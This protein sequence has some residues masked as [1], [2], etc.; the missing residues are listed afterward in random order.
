MHPLLEKQNNP[1]NISLLKAASVSYSEAKL[2]EVT[3]LRLMFFLAVVYL[4]IFV[5]IKNEEIKFAVSLFSFLF[6]ISM[7]V[8]VDFIKHKISNG[9]LLKEEFDTRVFELPWKFT[10]KKATRI[11]AEKLAAKYHGIGLTNWYPENFSSSLPDEVIIGACQRINAGWD[12]KIRKAFL[13]FLHFVITLYS[14]LLVTF[15]FLFAVDWFTVLLI[16]FSNLSFYVYF[17]NQIRGHNA[18]IKTRQNLEEILDGFLL[19]QK[20]IP[21]TEI[22][23]DVQ[24]EILSTRQS[25]TIVPDFYYRFFRKKHAA[26]FEK[27][28]DEINNTSFQKN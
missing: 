19:V 26:S 5:K 21:T 8:V 12:I 1:E 2:L 25:V 16:L 15:I 4:L 13:G 27:F 24:D 17:I 23:R 14:V 20:K 9:A 22:L 6:N 28:I 7:N 11:H 3:F 18:V 10:V